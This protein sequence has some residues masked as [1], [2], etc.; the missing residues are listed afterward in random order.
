VLWLFRIV[1]VTLPGTIAP[2]VAYSLDTTSHPVQMVSAAAMW[3]GW[4]AVLLA[5]FVPTAVSLTIV[6]L[7]APF[8]IL[9]AAI[10]SFHQPRPGA[11]ATAAALAA[12]TAAFVL[13]LVG[14]IGA[15]FI[16]GSAYGDERRFPLR[17]PLPLVVALLPGL[18][19]FVAGL[20]VVGVLAVGAKNWLLGMPFVLA[21]GAA[22]V[23]FGRR[24]HRLARRFAVFVPAGFVLHDHLVCAATAMFRRS[25]VRAF[26]LAP[27]DK[28]TMS[29]P[30]APA[31]L[32]GHAVGTGI[33]VTFANAET[34]VLAGTLRTR[35][36]RAIHV[37]SGRIVPTR[38]GAFLQEAARRGYSATPPASTH[39]S[40]SL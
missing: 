36:T 1:W 11:L 39:S 10:A 40:A 18:W 33:V 38:P 2:A 5:S 15:R 7:L 24:C 3:V 19:L 28:A 9:V 34:V 13:P 29:G 21:G 17:P 26:G 22:A 35:A 30:D 32:T 8:A 27:F 20:L 16:Q 4:F 37:R 31:D 12:G 14:E 23:L 6:R 25:D